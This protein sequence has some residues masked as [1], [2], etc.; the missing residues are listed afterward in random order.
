MESRHQKVSPPSRPSSED[1]YPTSTLLTS[2]PNTTL[3]HSSLFASSA[4]TRHPDFASSLSSSSF[5]NFATMFSSSFGIAPKPLSTA[6]GGSLAPV[7]SGEK[8]GEIL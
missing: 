1:P 3:S 4:N 7:P 6:G 2:R 5:D 8:K